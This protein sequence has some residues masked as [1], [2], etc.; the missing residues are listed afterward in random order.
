MVIVSTQSMKVPLKL[1]L[2]A[3][4]LALGSADFASSEF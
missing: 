3:I 2:S 4:G 1:R